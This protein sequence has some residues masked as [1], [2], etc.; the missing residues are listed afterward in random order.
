MPD[1]LWEIKKKSKLQFPPLGVTIKQQIIDA[2]GYVEKKS[3]SYILL[4][5]NIN[6]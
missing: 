6:S 3:N 2:G 4:V 1:T 5:G